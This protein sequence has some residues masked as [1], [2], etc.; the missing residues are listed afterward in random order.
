MDP[1]IQERK[2]EKQENM[3]LQVA[4]GAKICEIRKQCGLSQTELAARMNNRDRQVVQR[5]EK[6]KTN[7][8]LNLLRLIADGLKVKIKDLFDF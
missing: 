5:L 6:G 8:S 3:K 4:L 2:D 7:F 1:I